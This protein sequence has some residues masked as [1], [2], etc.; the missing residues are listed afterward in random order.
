MSAIKI[1]F[2]AASAMKRH[3]ISTGPFWLT[4]GRY[5]TS[6]VFMHMLD[7]IDDYTYVGKLVNQ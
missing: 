7:I 1:S 4:S 5:N 3:G 6:Q 2:K